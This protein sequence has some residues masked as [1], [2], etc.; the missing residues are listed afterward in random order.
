LISQAVLG[1]F[2]GIFTPDSKSVIYAADD[3]IWRVPITGGTPER[4][5]KRLSEFAFSPDGKLMF[6][7][8]QQIAGGAIQARFFVTPHPKTILYAY[9]CVCLVPG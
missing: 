8:S 2:G 4:Q 3:A 5:D 7:Q 6:H 1:F 9:V